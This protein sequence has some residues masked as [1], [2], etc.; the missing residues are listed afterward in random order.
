MMV[1]ELLEPKLQLPPREE[2]QQALIDK[3]FGSLGERQLQRLRRM[4]IIER[5]DG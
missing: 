5:R 1:C 4:A 2:I 3:I